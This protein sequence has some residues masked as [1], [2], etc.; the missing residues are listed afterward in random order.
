M[1]NGDHIVIPDTF[2][3]YSQANMYRNVLFNGKIK[4]KDGEV[5]NDEIAQI[6]IIYEQTTRV[7]LM[8]GVP[9]SKEIGF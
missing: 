6:N 5:D 3:L 8:N 7:E 1:K 9:P 2:E 4:T